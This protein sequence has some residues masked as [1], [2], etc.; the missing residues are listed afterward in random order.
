MK[1]IKLIKGEFD[2]PLEL[3]LAPGIRAGF[4]SPAEDYLRESLDFNLLSFLKALPSFC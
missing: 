3:L 1:N 2:K 4:P